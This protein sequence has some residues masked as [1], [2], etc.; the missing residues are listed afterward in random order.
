MEVLNVWDW[1]Y[2][3]ILSDSINQKVRNFIKI[4]QPE[5]KKIYEAMIDFYSGF[6]SF[7]V[8]LNLLQEDE[9]EQDKII[10]TAQKNIGKALKVPS[11]LKEYYKKRINSAFFQNNKLKEQLDQ[12]LTFLMDEKAFIETDEIQKVIFGPYYSGMKKAIAIQGPLTEKTRNL[13]KISDIEFYLN[14]FLSKIRKD[15]TIQLEFGK[16]IIPEYDTYVKEGAGFAEWWDRDLINKQRDLLVLYKNKDSLNLDD[17]EYTIYHEIYPGHG[18]FYNFARQASDFIPNFDHGAMSLIEGWATFCE[19]NVKETNYARSLRERGRR[20]LNISLLQQ[21]S[22]EQKI[23]SLYQNMLERGYSVDQAVN[24][25][26]YFSQYPGFTESYYLGA[27][28]IEEMIRNKVFRKPVDLLQYLRN[29]TWGELF[30][31]W[32]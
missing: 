28:C 11:V 9:A 8:L 25:I 1:K 21:S 19:W 31:L 24:T 4:L 7:D 23:S 18:Q 27:I 26:L 2:K 20:F 15:E 10:N 12:M 5:E 29:R 6:Y 14:D 16:Y 22:A 3:L 32:G 30:A 13:L 17:F